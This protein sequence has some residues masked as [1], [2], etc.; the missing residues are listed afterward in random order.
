[1]NEDAILEM[2]SLAPASPTPSCLNHPS[3][4]LMGQRR[5]SLLRPFQIPDTKNPYWLLFY[6]YLSPF[7]LLYQSTTDRVSYK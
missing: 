4:D 5:I 3:P 1:M 2:G 6:V 7:E